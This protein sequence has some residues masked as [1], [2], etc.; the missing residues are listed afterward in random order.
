MKFWLRHF[1]VMDASIPVAVALGLT[2]WYW[3][4]GGSQIVDEM[5]DGN[6]ANVYRTLAT[7]SG[8]LLGFSLAAASFAL[9]AVSS[10]RL[11]VLRNSPHYPTLWRTFFQTTWFLGAACVMAVVCIIWDREAAQSTWLTIPLTLAVG[12]SMVRLARVIHLLEKILVI[13]SGQPQ[14]NEPSPST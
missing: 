7:I 5:L 14:T 13:S 8:T 9:N 10:P 11:K 2:L 3:L 6:R 4:C 1:L 12:L